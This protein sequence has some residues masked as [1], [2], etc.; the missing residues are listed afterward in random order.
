ME[1][2]T[3]IVRRVISH[4]EVL[5]PLGT[6]GMGEVWVGFD[7]TLQRKVALKAVRRDR[8]LDE[9][10]RARLLRE[11]RVLSQLDHPN[12]CRVY[13]Y[14]EDEEHDYVVLEL[15]E[16][17]TLRAAQ[18]ESLDSRTKIRIAEGVGRALVAAHAA[19][20][21]HRDLKPDNIMLL[22]SG[23]VKVLDFGLATSMR[24]DAPPGAGGTVQAP[25][26]DPGF[27]T[28]AGT[29][30]V[31]PHDSVTREVPVLTVAG[32][33]VGTLLYM[34]P[35]QA[36]GD[37]ATAPSDMFAFGLVLQELFTGQP[38]YER[39]SDVAA[40]LAKVQ[41][42][43]TR[44][45]D[46]LGRDLTTLIQR[47]TSRVPTNRPTAVDAVD[48]LVAIRDA[49][50]R[51]RRYA[52]AAALAL[53]AIGGG[54][55]YTI[56]V[57]RERAAAIAAREEANQ[58]RGQAEDLIGFM[59]GDLR[60][61]LQKVGRLD[62]LDDVGRKAM[63]Y[64]AAVPA[65][66]LS[67]EEIL[68]RSQALHQLGQVRQAQGDMQAAVAAY[69]ESLQLIS[70]LAARDSSNREWQLA[71]ATSHFYAGDARRIQG[72][73]A[74]AMQDFSKYRDIA[75]AQHD[76]D[77]A[78]RTWMLELSYGHSNVAAAYE[79]LGDLASARRELE[80]SLAV[81]QRLVA[82]DP[83]NVEAVEAVANGH[84]RLGIVMTSMGLGAE[85]L[86]HFEADLRLR[87]QMLRRDPDN[88]EFQGEVAEAS[89]YVASVLLDQGDVARARPL[90]ATYERLFAA[91]VRRDPDNADWQRELANARLM[92]ARLERDQGNAGTALSRLEPAVVTLRALAQKSPTVV[93]RQRD[94][95][96]AEI[97]LAATHDA[98]GN[99][100]DTIRH[101]QEAVG[102]L[103]PLI[104]RA[105]G[106]TQARG[107]LAQAH[108]V[109]GAAA[110][111][112]GDTAAAMDHRQRAYDTIAPAIERS[113]NRRLRDV[114]A[115]VLRSLG[116][117]AEAEQ[118]IASLTA[119]GYRSAALARLS[120]PESSR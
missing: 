48:R 105:G 5:A 51:R 15:I 117:T 99:A 101:A 21:I 37:P 10:A 66:A 107:L 27:D 81:K 7:T 19:G 56:D 70:S 9:Q 57:T 103:E 4:Y 30:E 22:A 54:V 39:E 74:G 102:I 43:S 116:R 53:A 94:W 112:R 109:L 20:V 62:V 52:A 118:V 16:G 14:V 68:R 18:A 2:S 8:R 83:G 31:R 90:L 86:Q 65:S 17:M 110:A 114:M 34:S 108:L 26:L 41:R 12:I 38:A 25:V 63:A 42:G 3:S 13:D 84:N 111:R 55:K 28:T 11:A 87:E 119:T 104:A 95:A 79:A 61:R 47:L 44:A 32:S 69:Q 23:D 24:A 33:L 60:T 46:G 91:L 106:D 64:F 1:E 58:R 75:K 67:N 93:R 113:R 98:L 76:R 35:E 77:P 45:V 78:D 50:K 88:P 97:E 115:Q 59:L 73:A 40:V 36:I 80:F 82:L 6:G 100:A 89:S 49:P 71:L 85:A 92:Q 96:L 29:V 72:D 120:H